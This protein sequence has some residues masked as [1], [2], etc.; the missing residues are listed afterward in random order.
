[1]NKRRLFTFF[2]RD[3]LY[4]FVLVGMYFAWHR[5]VQQVRV[6]HQARYDELID[7]NRELERENAQVRARADFYS[8]NINNQISAINASLYNL[9]QLVSKRSVSSSE[10]LRNADN[11]Q[12]ASTK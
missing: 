6:Q 4:I 8:A 7:R 11:A 9:S 3:A 10:E 2:I 5:D 12:K 1:M